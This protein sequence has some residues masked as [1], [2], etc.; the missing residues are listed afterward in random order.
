[1]CHFEFS[2]AEKDEMTWCKADRFFVCDHCWEKHCDRGHGNWLKNKGYSMRTAGYAVLFICALMVPVGATAVYDYA[3]PVQWNM[4]PVTTINGLSDGAV[5]KVHGVLNASDS[6]DGVA[7]GGRERPARNGWFWEWNETA[8][9]SIRDATGDIEVVAADYF[10]IKDPANPAPNALHTGHPAYFDGEEA[11]IVG[12]VVDGPGGQILQ[13][14]AITPGEESIDNDPVFI[15]SGAILLTISTVIIYKWASIVISRKRDHEAKAGYLPSA[16]IPL[17]RDRKEEGLEWSGH[18]MTDG[19]KS[20]IVLGA[21]EI[22]MMILVGVLVFGPLLFKPHAQ[23]DF[24]LIPIVIGFL[25]D[26]C[27]IGFLVMIQRPF[28]PEMAVSDKGIH[29]WYSE[30]ACRL[31]R[32][33]VV[34]WPEIKSI[35]L[36]SGKAKYWAL[37]MKNGEQINVNSCGEPAGSLI[38]AKWEQIKESRKT[39]TV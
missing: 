12:K 11:T 15:I 6:A 25:F 30:P 18:G 36:G 16:N 8:R 35:D 37:M 20:N 2:K 13:M 39:G 21:S 4:L 17:D 23:L 29:F 9:F 38:R 34:V 24:I 22:G 3:L 7:L 14:R 26:S 1:M 31:L 33:N 28:G 32:R 10:I 19:R 27:L 5:V